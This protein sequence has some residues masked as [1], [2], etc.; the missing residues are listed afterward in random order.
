MS[1]VHLLKTSLLFEV[2]CSNLN[3]TPCTP[4][5]LE[6]TLLLSG[7]AACWPRMRRDTRPLGDSHQTGKGESMRQKVKVGDKLM[8][9]RVELFWVGC[10]YVIIRKVLISD[11][12]N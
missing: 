3:V 1:S 5:L 12:Q 8:R 7:A 2:M 11:N 9:H 4:P 10:D 6:Q